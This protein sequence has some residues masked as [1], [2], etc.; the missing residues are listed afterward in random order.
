VVAIFGYFDWRKIY[1]QQA[2]INPKFN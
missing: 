2:K 1:R